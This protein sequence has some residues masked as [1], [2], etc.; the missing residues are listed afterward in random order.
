MKP[1]KIVD[2]RNKSQDVELDKVKSTADL[3]IKIRQ[4]D[5]TQSATP[6]GYIARCSLVAGHEGECNFD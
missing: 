5:K 1:L 4:C 2:D 6:F 3:V